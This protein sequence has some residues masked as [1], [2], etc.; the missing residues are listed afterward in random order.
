VNQPHC[1]PGH[2]RFFRHGGIYRSDVVP[3]QN[4][5][6]PQ[7]PRWGASR[8]SAR[9]RGGRA[10][11]LYRALLIVHDEFRPA[12]PRSGCSPAEPVSASPAG[13]WYD[14][15]GMGDN[16]S[17]ANGNCP[18]TGL[19]QKRAQSKSP[20]ARPAILYGGMRATRKENL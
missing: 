19:S 18:K 2:V 14:E 7:F 15:G 20:T 17:T 1:P 5:N 9:N 8:W 10:R 6:H 13:P 3:N 16:K 12:I 4:Q 11:L